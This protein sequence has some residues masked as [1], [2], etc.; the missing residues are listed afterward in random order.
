MESL[1]GERKKGP[2]SYRD[3]CDDY[4]RGFQACEL[5]TDELRYSTCCNFP[6][7]AMKHGDL[8]KYQK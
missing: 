4:L 7:F 8:K 5:E 2:C 3:E 1:D 6:V